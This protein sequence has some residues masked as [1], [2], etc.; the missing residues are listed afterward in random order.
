MEFHEG[1]NGGPWEV[2]ADLLPTRILGQETRR[3]R[4]KEG[5]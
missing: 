1:G 2:G 3:L 4:E 5:V